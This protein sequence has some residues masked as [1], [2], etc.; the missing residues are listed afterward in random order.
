MAGGTDVTGYLEAAMRASSLRARVIANNIANIQTPGYRRRVV[1]FER[2][3]AEAME[4]S[5]RHGLED[6]KAQIRQPM[7]NPVD[8]NNNDVVLEQEIGELLKNSARYRI[9]SRLL[10]RAYRQMEMA[11]SDRLTP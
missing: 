2:L 3:L 9:Y 11:M 7:T 8:A 4:S 10:A 5:N 1:E 6:L